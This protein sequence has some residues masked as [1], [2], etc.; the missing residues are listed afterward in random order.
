MRALVEFSVLA[1]GG[2][3]DVEAV[4]ASLAD[5][6]WTT[7]DIGVERGELVAMARDVAVA[8]GKAGRDLPISPHSQF[9]QSVIDA[10]ARFDRFSFERHCLEQALLILTQIPEID[11]GELYTREMVTIVGPEFGVYG[12]IL[13]RSPAHRGTAADHY[14]VHLRCRDLERLQKATAA[15]VSAL[16]PTRADGAVAA[17]AAREPGGR[18]RPGRRWRRADPGGSGFRSI[19]SR[20]ELRS[21]ADELLF[22]AHVVPIG[23]R[24]APLQHSF[25]DVPALLLTTLSL[26]LTAAS[27]LMFWLGPG[28][29]W[30]QW[31]EQL[32][33]R[34]ATG[35]FGALLVEGAIA[36]GALRRTLA[37]SAGPAGHGALLDWNRA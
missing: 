1:G 19:V 16:N 7:P 31:A 4:V 3:R 37:S 12:L 33:G 35:A 22:T 24:L 2:P 9:I 11:H 23:G 32:M 10:R 21:E 8:A 34:L 30:W 25:A 28:E 13:H 27:A 5:Y 17:A 15:F 29:G 18:R 14:I 6:G 26:V 36:Y 20:L